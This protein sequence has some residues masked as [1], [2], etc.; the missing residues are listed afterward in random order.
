[1]AVKPLVM[2]S[3]CLAGLHTRYDGRA[4]QHPPLS[5]LAN[6]VRLAPVC[7]EILGGLGIPPSPCHFVGGDGAAALR[8]DA[9]LI[10]A[11][12]VDRTSFFLRAADE[13]RRMVEP[14]CPDLILFEEGSPSCGIH[15]VD[16]EG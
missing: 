16:I 4:N 13:T 2:I 9:R 10:D 6:M 3:A 11:T 14:V 12:G 1:M 5:E 8:G 7:P 15:R